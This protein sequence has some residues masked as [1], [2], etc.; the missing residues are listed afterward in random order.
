M[1]ANVDVTASLPECNEV[2]NQRARHHADDVT[3]TLNATDLQ[4]A[5]GCEGVL[6]RYK[7]Y[8]V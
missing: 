2:G 1:A 4:Q 6:I 8:E 7:L 3:K 5:Q